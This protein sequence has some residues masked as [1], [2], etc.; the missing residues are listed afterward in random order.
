MV[1]EHI[2][3]GILGS[4]IHVDY[5][6]MLGSVFGARKSRSTNLEASQLD[7]PTTRPQQL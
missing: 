1:L 2:I 4:P 5:D 7:R 6:S 3:F